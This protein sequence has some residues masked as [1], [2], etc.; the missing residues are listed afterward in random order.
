VAQ[1]AAAP[2]RAAGSRWLP[3]CRADAALLRR[4]MRALVIAHR[5]RLHGT[6]ET[7][8]SELGRLLMTDDFASATGRPGVPNQRQV[9]DPRSALSG[10]GPN[11]KRDARSE[12]AGTDGWY[13]IFSACASQPTAYDLRVRVTTGCADGCMASACSG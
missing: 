9:S 8:A 3:D 11:A 1:R 5:G 2:G 4:A 7:A 13:V 6:A 12:Q 10:V